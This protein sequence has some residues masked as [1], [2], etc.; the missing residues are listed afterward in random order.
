AELPALSRGFVTFGCLNNFCKIND[1]VLA[2]WSKVLVAV[3]NSRL[4]LLTNPGSHRQRT[5]DALAGHSVCEERVQF[6]PFQP[7]PAYMACYNQIDISLDTLPYNGHT[8]S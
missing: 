8:T 2:L 1:D 4:L 5:I 6:I 3:P 7:R